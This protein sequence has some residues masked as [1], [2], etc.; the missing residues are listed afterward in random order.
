MN[1]ITKKVDDSRLKRLIEFQRNFSKD[2]RKIDGKLI[3]IKDGGSIH[4]HPQNPP[5][6]RFLYGCNVCGSYFETDVK[7]VA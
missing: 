7:Q 2:V 4:E 5:Y 1:V 6:Y 3:H